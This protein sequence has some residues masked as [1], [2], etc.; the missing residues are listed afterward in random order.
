MIIRI[1]RFA[2]FAADFQ[3]FFRNRLA[4]MCP[5][6]HVPRARASSLSLGRPLGLVAAAVVAAATAGR[7]AA[8]RVVPVAAADRTSS[9]DCA[10]GKQPC[11][12]ADCWG[13]TMVRAWARTE[14]VFVPSGWRPTLERARQDVD[15]PH[16][17]ELRQGPVPHDIG[18]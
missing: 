2:D 3:M 16:R 12:T 8:Q 5:A 10:P 13:A 1:I 6:C 11:R 4:W 7:V 18:I 14:E 9:L 17:P 15:H